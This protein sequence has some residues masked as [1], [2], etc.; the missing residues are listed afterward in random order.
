MKQELNQVEVKAI[1]M[2]FYLALPS[3]CLPSL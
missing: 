3:A 2:D 1:C